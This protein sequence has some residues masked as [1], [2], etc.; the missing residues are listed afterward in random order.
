MHLKHVFC[1]EI[2][3]FGILLAGFSNVVYAEWRCGYNSFSGIASLCVPS[4][5]AL[6]NC[7]VS[8]TGV[9]GKRLK[10]RLS[11]TGVQDRKK[12]SGDLLAEQ[13]KDWK[14]CN[15]AP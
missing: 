7:S 12:G 5:F 1:D 6:T 15:V 3:S 4:I 2:V 13:T 8:I 14:K 10:E 9:R 11:P